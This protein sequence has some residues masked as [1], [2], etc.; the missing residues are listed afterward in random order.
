[1]AGRRDQAMKCPKCQ[2]IGFDSSD[3]CRNCGYE[4]SLT[5]NVEALDLPILTG[6]EPEGP[7]AELA[8][9]D[10]DRV[11]TEPPPP[12]GSREASTGLQMRGTGRQGAAS[13]GRH[14]TAGLELPLFRDRAP[15]DDAPLVTP[16]AVPR[17]PL[18]VRRKAPAA[19]R[20]RP[21]DEVAEPGEGFDQPAG[22]RPTA[23]RRAVT[24]AAGPAPR[25]PEA[26]RC[27]GAVARLLAA[28]ID[29][30]ILGSL[31]FVVVH[32]TL[33]LTRLEFADLDLLPKVPLLTFLLLLNGGYLVAFTAAGGQTIGKMAT[34]I[35]V[36]PAEPGGRATERVPL[37]QAVLRV[38]GCALSLLPAGLGYLPALVGQDRRAL[39]DRLADTRVI[40]L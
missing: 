37:R 4:F 33:Q 25:V 14:T 19:P 5:V 36:V 40:T 1:M 3:R 32:F 13:S 23:P 22:P 12:S 10:L 2:Y 11:L 16:A 7:L 29:A 39:H 17:A 15:D 31:T 34:G 30:L 18:A 6:D 21:R 24:P 27:A 9:T 38:A 8:L 28:A 35:R 20:A 26:A